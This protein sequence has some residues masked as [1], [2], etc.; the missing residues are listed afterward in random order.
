MMKHRLEVQT[1]YETRLAQKV[2]QSQEID[3]ELQGARRRLRAA[4]K[5][6]LPREELKKLTKTLASIK[7][8]LEDR[9]VSH[10]S[11]HPPIHPSTHPSIPYPSIHPSIVLSIIRLPI[12]CLPTT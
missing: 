3:L 2:L 6:F 5:K 9:E 7:L 8:S 1:S 10:P 12:H 11:T 4:R